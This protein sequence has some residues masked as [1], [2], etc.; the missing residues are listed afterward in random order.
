MSSD[1]ALEV[2]SSEYTYIAKDVHGFCIVLFNQVIC[3]IADSLDLFLIFSGTD[4]LSDTWDSLIL[5][6]ARDLC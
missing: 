5:E 2:G 4:T 1:H 3:K 6:L